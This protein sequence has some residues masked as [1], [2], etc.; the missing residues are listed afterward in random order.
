M[1][2]QTQTP[3]KVSRKPRSLFT[4]RTRPSIAPLRHSLPPPEFSSSQHKPSQLRS[5]LG[6]FFLLAALGIHDF[7]EN[8]KEYASAITMVFITISL[9]IQWVLSWKC[10]RNGL[11]RKKDA[12]KG[13]WKRLCNCLGRKK[14]S[15]L[16]IQQ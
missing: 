10:V 16:D 6:C 15:A 8:D 5:L 9:G 12:M 13:L 14:Y 3:T 2:M 1:Q 7:R 4:A 11:S